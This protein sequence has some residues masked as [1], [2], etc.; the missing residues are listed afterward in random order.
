MKLGE[1]VV[2]MDNFNFMKFQQNQM[3]NQKVLLIAHFS[4]QNFKA[5]VESWKSYIV[6]V[7]K[8]T[9]QRGISVPCSHKSSKQGDVSPFSIALCSDSDGIRILPWD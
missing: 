6:W 9:F 3:K 8:F 7:P 1:I 5:L 2:H 4:V